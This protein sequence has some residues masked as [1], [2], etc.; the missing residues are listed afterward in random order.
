M[1]AAVF[2]L[3]AMILIFPQSFFIL[4]IPLILFILFGIIIKGA[5]G[6]LKLR[7]HWYI[8]YYFIFVFL[9][10]I[11]SAIG[12]IRG[13][14]EI[15]VIESIRLY[16]I[17]MLLYMIITLYVSNIN[18]YR[19]VDALFIL[20]SVG[21]SFVALWVLLDG[22]FSIQ[23]IPTFIAEEMLLEIGIHDGYIQMNNI[24]I[25][26]LNFIA[27]YLLARFLVNEKS[28]YKFL[29]VFALMAAVTGGILA[30]RRIVLVVTLLAPVLTLMLIRLVGVSSRGIKVKVI[31]FYSFIALVFI[32]L[33]LTDVAFKDGI[34]DR[35]FSIF[36]TDPNEPRPLQ[37]LALMRGF[38]DHPILGSGFGGLTS[39]VRSY[40][41]PWTYELTYS[42]L[43]FNS[44]LMGLFLLI[45]FFLV[46]LFRV[47]IKLKKSEMKDIQIPLL[48]GLFSVLIAAASNPYLSSFDFLFV[49]SIIP[50]IINSE[51]K[52]KTSITHTSRF[53]MTSN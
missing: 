17:Y 11:W 46:F 25:G 28:G 41:R 34:L 3:L 14:P 35:L 49:F 51:D 8:Y 20:S 16:V 33:T 12:L 53:S 24:N 32:S 21:I 39:E 15:A 10:L 4:K 30:S 36:N 29:L 1:S 22:V 38:M 44:G 5:Q 19:G 52:I 23:T 18:Y 7:S 27:P 43:L 37:H 31:F 2:S 13:N 45:A 48:V 50:L 6:I 42:K 26:M 47:I 40:D 9:S